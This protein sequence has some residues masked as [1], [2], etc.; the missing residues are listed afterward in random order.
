MSQRHEPKAAKLATLSDCSDITSGNLYPAQRYRICRT[1]QAWIPPIFGSR[2]PSKKSLFILGWSREPLPSHHHEWLRLKVLPC[3]SSLL[4][5]HAHQCFDFRVSLF[6]ANGEH[7]STFFFLRPPPNHGSPWVGAQSTGNS[8]PNSKYM[9]LHGF[10]LQK[11]NPWMLPK[12]A[13]R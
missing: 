9:Y 1:F 6:S 10:D 7:S 2:T 11:L 3:A 4:C 13:L 5:T 8:M 12:T